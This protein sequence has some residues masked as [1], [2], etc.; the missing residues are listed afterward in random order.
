MISDAVYILRRLAQA[1]NSD[2]IFF[3]LAIRWGIFVCVFWTLLV[4]Y[5]VGIETAGLPSP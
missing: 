2:R 3:R 1:M 5:V 4:A